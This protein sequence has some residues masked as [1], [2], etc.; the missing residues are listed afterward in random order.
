MDKSGIQ[1][2]NCN[3]DLTNV[4]PQWARWLSRLEIFVDSKG[5]IV[6]AHKADNK[7]RRALLLHLA[8]EDVQDIFLTLSDTGDA[9]NYQKAVD[10]L[11][12]YFVPKKNTAHA[13][14][15]FKHTVINP[16]ESVSPYYVR[17][18]TVVKDYGFGGDQN[19]QLETRSFSNVNQITYNAD[20]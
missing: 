4:G 2:F 7:Q 14:H 3:G 18:R 5:L 8:E 16:G 12:M 9:N 15:L 10:A 13:N 11:N 1:K 19:N 6:V 20:Y 17:L